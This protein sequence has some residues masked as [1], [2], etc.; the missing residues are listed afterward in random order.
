M[1]LRKDHSVHLYTKYINK[2]R[3]YINE[4]HG[5]SVLHCY[6]EVFLQIKSSLLDIYKQ[7]VRPRG[8]SCDTTLLRR[9][10][11]KL[12]RKIST[13]LVFND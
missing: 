10:M 6:R 11:G 8:V 3:N 13:C 5:N 2:T 4:N 1:K 7:K 9:I 12:W